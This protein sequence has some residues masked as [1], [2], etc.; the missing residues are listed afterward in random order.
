[1]TGAMA[2]TRRPELWRPET[3][4][5][6]SLALAALAAWPTLAHSVQTAR[7]AAALFT[8]GVTLYEQ[9]DYSGAQ[10]QWESALAA[11]RDLGLDAEVADTLRR[12]GI[13]AADLGQSDKALT[14]H[15]EA[16]ALFRKLRRD[17]DIA[18]TLDR[19]GA[20]A[21]DLVQY[22][23]ALAYGQEALA[24]YRTLALKKEQAAALRTLG[25]VSEALTQPDQARRYYEQAARAFRDLGLTEDARR[26]DLQAADLELSEGRL[27]A[28]QLLL[29]AGADPI[30]WGRYH[31]LSGRPAEAAA[32]FE[33]AL[34]G[35][36]LSSLVAAHLG[37]GLAREALGQWGPA[38]AAYDK[39]AALLERARAS[40]PPAAR[41]RFFQ[42]R[43]VGF[44]RLEAYEGL[45]RVRLRQGQPEEAF[46][47][48]ESAKARLLVDALARAAYEDPLGS[49]TGQWVRIEGLLRVVFGSA[50]GLGLPAEPREMEDALTGRIAVLSRRL[51]T[52][53][54][55]RTALE[56]QLTPLQ[57][58]LDA[59]VGRLRREYPEYAAMRYPQPVRAG[60][61]VLAPGEV[62]LSYAVTSSETLAFLVR[63]GRVARTFEVK[64]PREE[65]ANLIARHRQDYEQVAE[66][67]DL[68]RLDLA[69]S[70]RLYRL[71]LQGP[72][73]A[74]SRDERVV[75]V[76]DDAIGLV[77]FE[78]LVESLPDPLMWRDGPH[79]PVP[80]G[81]QYVGDR[82]TFTY[83]QSATA[84]RLVRGR[85]TPSDG[86]QVL[87]VA[88]P[89]FETSDPRV[90]GTAVATVPPEGGLHLMREI[91]E[92]LSSTYG[93]SLF[94]RLPITASLVSTLRE[95][96]GDKLTAWQGFDATENKL[97]EARLE[98]Y[99]VIVFA[100]HGVLDGS[101]PWLR[102]R[103]L[104]LGLVG[105][106]P[107]ADGY[108]TMAEVMALKL[109]A[110]VVALM[111]CQSGAGRVISG[112]GTMGMARAFQYAGARSVLA[113][114]W[115]VED[116]STNLLAVAFLRGLSRGE[117][118]PSALSSAQRALRQAGYD[119]PFFW[120]P[121]VLV[122][123]TGSESEPPSGPGPA[124]TSLPTQP[125]VSSPAPAHPSLAARA[126]PPAQIRDMYPRFLTA[127]QG[128]QF[129]PPAPDDDVTWVCS[130]PP[131]ADVYVALASEVTDKTELLVEEYHLGRTPVTLYLAP[132]RYVIAVNLEC[133]EEL[134]VARVRLSAGA[135]F[136]MHAWP[137]L[138]VIGQ[139]G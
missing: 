115:S 138:R 91:K 4:L 117:T 21:C 109:N 37:L 52:E 119:H 30:R 35:P 60:D 101:V 136:E 105:N 46:Y 55:Q 15:D 106:E 107:G 134:G 98:D 65:L 104:V 54:G 99:G 88:D 28:A 72:L 132:G 121:F 102:Q 11:Y 71:L 8:D 94:R 27:A 57:A 2:G 137:G 135:P 83:W 1:M 85:E 36:G 45:A 116:E 23:R 18:D 120:A 13:V 81:V 66:P 63:D 7:G 79:G 97:K 68:K 87:V 61:V 86:K 51:E 93:R 41:G 5:R 40:T 78:G 39:A 77:P 20:V 14:Y 90:A 3:W 131:G 67:A 122:G 42:A 123:G 9:Q 16:L 113:S 130:L 17:K 74:V 118:G 111:A 73:S 89:I 126:Q 48:G 29:Q 12:L 58:D 110:Q 62:L 95:Q 24:L 129:Q 92:G 43:D 47:W 34:A 59:F 127:L 114:L 70:H 124:P 80:Q 139:A 25:E 44:R 33:K 84:L 50:P 6:V 125:P 108:L 26:T 75:V 100:T 32:Q 103:A 82:R 53:P 19:L 49:A 64:L 69:L 56:A 128:V 96:Y 10:R 76:P 112:E 38:A 133:T 22:D 31:L